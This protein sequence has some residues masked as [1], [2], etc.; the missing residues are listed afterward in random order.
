M[1]VSNNVRLSLLPCAVAIFS[2]SL[3]SGCKEKNVEVH[4]DVLPVTTVTVRAMDIPA[5]LS[6]VAKAESSRKV[7]IFSRISGF[8]EKR[9]YTEGGMVQAG[10]VLFTIDP[11]PFEVQLKQAEAALESSRAAHL[12]AQ[13]NLNRI[14]PLAKIKALSQTDL[15]NAVAQFNTTEAQVSIS[16]AQVES[17]K[18]NLSYCTITSPVTGLV[19]SA[20]QTDGTYINMSNS[21]L[22][23]VYTMSPM[24]IVFSMSENERQK[25]T[26]EVQ[27]GRLV[28]PQDL[29]FTTQIQIGNGEVLPQEGVVT[30]QSPNYNPNTGTFEIRSSIENPLGTLK[31]Q[32][33]VRAI[34]KGAYYRNAISVPQVAVQQGAQSHYVWVIN[35]DKRAEYRP[36]SVGE[37]VGSNWVITSGLK[38]G[39][40]VVTSGMLMLGNEVP[41]TVLSNKDQETK[42]KDSVNQQ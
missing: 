10:D 1:I 40:Q 22:T 12:S 2:V 9:Q 13:Q 8:L 4:S 34:L 38:D 23:T 11:K 18:L 31:P 21:H 42:T 33:Y 36:V 32:Q 37:W 27:E 20:L 29:R 3:L 17:A 24:W 5:D 7:D 6:Y 35:K 39:D 15:D 26:Q 25:L 19:G 16:K 30:F 41:V 14:R 28:L